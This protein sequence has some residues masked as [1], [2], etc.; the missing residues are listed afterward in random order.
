MSGAVTAKWVTGILCMLKITSLHFPY[1]PKVN[2]VYTNIESKRG[3]LLSMILVLA[4]NAHYHST[5]LCQGSK[6]RNNCS[7]V[8]Q[9]QCLL[10][11]SELC[12][13]GPIISL[14]LEL[15]GALT[16]CQHSSTILGCFDN[17]STKPY[18]DDIFKT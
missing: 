15:L 2:Q 11:V 3:P 17:L 6:L 8:F 18:K 1:N 5:L 10:G 12:T 13:P 14:T 7:K 4:I 16:T 9:R